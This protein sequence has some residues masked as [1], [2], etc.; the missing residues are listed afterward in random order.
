VRSRTRLALLGVA[1][2]IAAAAVTGVVT[3]IVE[4][5]VNDDDDAVST[6][7]QLPEVTST[8]TTAKVTTATGLDPVA[9]CKAL[10]TALRDE[11][12]RMNALPD[13]VRVQG[14]HVV[15][16]RP[17]FQAAHVAARNG[18]A[19]I[20][21]AYQNYDAAGRPPVP[22]RDTVPMG[23]PVIE[24]GTSLRQLTGPDAGD[25]DDAYGALENW[26]AKLDNTA[27]FVS[28]ACA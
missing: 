28:K 9:A 16:Y 13:Q 11:R 2:V 6:S 3:P 20:A 10:L 4:D 17:G 8:S 21:D 14:E 22:D 19:E 24:L 26:A 27:K 25:R 1:G 5:W 18:Q 23:D 7:T 12:D 15:G